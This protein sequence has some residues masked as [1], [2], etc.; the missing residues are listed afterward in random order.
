VVVEGGLILVHSGWSPL[1][2]LAY[3]FGA[4]PGAWLNPASAVPSTFIGGA[5]MTEMRGFLLPSFMHSFKLM[6]ETKQKPRSILPLIFAVIVV[7]FGVGLWQNLNLGYKD[8]ALNLMTWWARKPGGTAPG[9]N[10]REFVKG[11][12][13]NFA[14]NWFFV[15]VCA[16]MTWLIVVA[17]SRF[18]W[19][20]LH[21]IGLIMCVPYALHTFWFSIFMG[22]FCKRLIMRYG[23]VQAY[24]NATPFFLGMILG[25]VSMMLFWLAIDCYFGRVEHLLLPR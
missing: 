21:P 5:V 20:S 19:F 11:I 9:Q 23:G 2:P 12:E 6:Q 8:G 16:T 15:M 3:L 22:W 4:G 18:A 1:G 25:D 14:L 7:A 17:R 24:R 10:S 13:G